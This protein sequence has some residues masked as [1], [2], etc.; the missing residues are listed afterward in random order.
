MAHITHTNTRNTTAV[1]E[2]GFQIA[3]R[4]TPIIEAAGNPSADVKHAVWL[5]PCETHGI[6]M[7]GFW[8]G[9]VLNKT[10]CPSEVCLSIT[11]N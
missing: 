6:A 7:E 3:E 11:V 10:W 2:V 4:M 9:S 5:C 8:T 1:D